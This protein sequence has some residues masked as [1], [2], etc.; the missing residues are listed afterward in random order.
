VLSGI[1]AGEVIYNK[2]LAGKGLAREIIRR[3]ARLRYIILCD[4]ELPFYFIGP[5]PKQEILFLCEDSR[6][7]KRLIRRGAKCRSGKLRG[8][9]IYQRLKICPTDRIG[10]FSRDEK[11]RREILQAVMEHTDV[12]AIT[13][14]E[15]RG[16]KRTS[17]ASTHPRVRSVPIVEL[18]QNGLI[19]ELEK[20]IRAAHLRTLRSIFHDQ[21]R[22]LLLVQY[23]PDPDA[24]ASA[25]AMRTLLGRNKL[26]APIASFGRVTRPENLAMLK[27]LD[28]EILQITLEE[29]ED[30]NR[31]VLLDV[32][33]SHFREE[34]SP[35]HVII[36]HHPENENA[37]CL[38]K[39]IRPNYGATSTIL[40]EYLHAGDVKITQKLAT[41]LLYGI[42][43]DTLL[44]E[45][46]AIEDDLRAYSYLY[47]MANHRLIRRME[48]PQLPKEDLSVLS[49]A[50]HQPSIV[51]D[52]IYVHLDDL[53]REDI[54]PYIADFCLEVEGIEWAVVSGVYDGKIVVS[55]RNYGT[56]RSAGELMRAAFSAYGSAGGHRSMAKAVIPL[57]SLDEKDARDPQQFLRRRFLEVYQAV[58]KNTS[59]P[60]QG[61]KNGGK[62]D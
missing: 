61:G 27:L 26:S 5:D 32:Q 44:L 34:L 30:Y 38:F 6:L 45:R 52:V 29:L 11:A 42:K 50:F 51:D 16:R 54:V 9:A 53:T 43:T 60:R 40:Q 17:A 15:E 48:R 58:L 14:V 47:P 1:A 18:V 35:V 37:V 12:Y 31:I 25:L 59:P 41:A 39:D 33:P 23:D 10:V 3:E 20:T 19:N 8:R 24:V 55:A 57:D 22:V 36:D 62:G 28:I 7:Q 13:L 46:E 49:K 2:I 56:T 4:D 21:E